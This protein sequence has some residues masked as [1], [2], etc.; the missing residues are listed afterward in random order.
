MGHLSLLLC[1]KVHY[2]KILSLISN[3]KIL[4]YFSPKKKV[5]E[6]FGKVKFLKSLVEFKLMTHRFVVNTL[7]H[8]ATLISDNYGKETIN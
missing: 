4:Q 5:L 1:I 3:F 7:T 6:F 8:C 2:K